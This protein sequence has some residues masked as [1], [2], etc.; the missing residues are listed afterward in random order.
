M[1]TY[2]LIV[3]PLMRLGLK[4]V[5]AFQHS[6]R[7]RRLAEVPPLPICSKDETGE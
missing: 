6:W 5:R 2:L 3:Q 1:L 7:A 4:K